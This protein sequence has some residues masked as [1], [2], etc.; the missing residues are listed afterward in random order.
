MV[1]A[2]PDPDMIVKTLAFAPVFISIANL[3]QII[4][5]LNSVD[6]GYDINEIIGTHV[7]TLIP[8]EQ[9]PKSQQAF[10]KVLATGTVHHFETFI[11]A[12]GV[13]RQWYS[14]SIAPVAEDG[15]APTAFVYT[16]TNITQQRLAEEQLKQTQEE[17]LEASHRA[18]MSEVATGVLHNIGNVLNSVNVSASLMIE[19]V[20]ASQLGRLNRAVSLLE[21]HEDQLATFLSENPKGKLLPAFL[22]KI[23]DE[24]TG[25]QARLRRELGNLVEHVGLIR[26]TV[27]AQQSLAKLGA[28]IEE[29][30]PEQLLDRALALF[31]ID[32]D[33]LAV[34]VSVTVEDPR[35]IAIDK[36]ATLQI[37]ANL[38]RNA[39]E[40]LATVAPPRSLQLRYHTDA[41][42]LYVEVADNGAGITGDAIDKVFSHGFTTKKT[43]HGFGL[44]SSSVAA[45]TMKGT[46]AVASDGEGQGARFTLKLPLCRS[47]AALAAQR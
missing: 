34:Q 20:G 7:D 4:V 24:L 8:P 21:T 29:I 23:C 25:E 42:W 43:G 41:N 14:T 3:D 46:L 35:Q 10:A 15:A 9:R 1:A 28:M 5:Y 32:I 37:L 39:V 19:Q 30:E 18:G 13:E 12:P 27:T 31:R 11:D 22:R 17:L 44:H 16:T 38:V 6:E 40:S 26:S 36:Q 33:N 2:K 47:D 45:E